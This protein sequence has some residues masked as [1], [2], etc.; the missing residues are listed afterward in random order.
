[1]GRLSP[2]RV[3]TVRLDEAEKKLAYEEKRQQ[4]IAAYRRAR[5]EGS[6]LPQLAPRWVLEMMR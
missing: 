4:T 5:A 2:S 1:M 6:P 3:S